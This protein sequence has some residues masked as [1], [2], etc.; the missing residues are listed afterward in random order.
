MVLPLQLTDVD[1]EDGGTYD[2]AYPT[3][4][5]GDKKQAA[6]D[7]SDEEEVSDERRGGG[8][9]AS[10]TLNGIITFVTGICIHTYVHLVI[11]VH[12]CI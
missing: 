1:K 6:K 11:H 8:V 9:H 4:R 2:P 7:E 5:G 10:G 3:S 12:V